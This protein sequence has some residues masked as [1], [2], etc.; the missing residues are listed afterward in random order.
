MKYKILCEDNNLNLIER[1]LHIR[2]IDDDI[3]NFLNPKMKDYWLNPFDLNDMQKAVD[4]IISAMK[5]DEKIMIF[6]DY[7]VDWVTSS[8]SLFKFFRKYLN[9][10]NVSIMYPSRL[11]DG[12]G[13]KNKHLDDMKEKGIDLVITVDNWIT[14]I[15]EAK[16]AKEIG[17]DLIITDHHQNL[18]TL[19]TA[20]AVINPVVSDNYKFKSLAWVGVAFKLICALLESSNISKQKR[21]EAFN[22]FLP[23]AAIWTVADIVPLVWENRLIVKKWLE[24]INNDRDNIPESLRWFLEFL[25]I[26]DV[27]TFHI[28][29]VIWPRINAGWR[30]DSPYKSLNT[31]LYTWEKQIQALTEIDEINTNRKKL[32]ETAFKQAEEMISN[33]NNIIIAKSDEFHEGVVWIVSG[34]LTEKYN[35]PSIVFKINEEEWKAVASLRWP[36]YFNVID[37][38]QNFWDLLERSGWHKQAW[39]LTIKLENLAKFEEEVI[40]YCNEN[41]CENDLEKIIDIDTKIYPWEFTN[42][43]I[44]ELQNLWP[45]GE[46]NNEPL[47]LFENLK[48]EKVEKV[49]K[50]GNWHMKIFTKFGDQKINCLFWWKWDMIKSI[51]N[52]DEINIVWKIKKDDFNGWY[53]VNGVE[54]I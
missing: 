23:I 4:R 17:L 52:Q 35:K 54:I 36:K 25:N 27:D 12:Y 48:V 15:Q 39:W 30:I 40:N 45:F 21:N 13:L 20:L 10:E 8:F 53:F 19:P 33:D 16:Y 51:E 50:N 47:F 6:G 14:S 5:N 7:D 1:L 37:M 9:Y 44:A 42:K 22:Y 31:L 46:G 28:W 11:K 3:S 41:I 38:I 2:G 32:Q 43:N 18:E 34:R 29:F 49:W 26:K 24:L